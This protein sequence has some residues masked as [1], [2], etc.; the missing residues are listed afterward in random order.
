MYLPVRPTPNLPTLH[1]R[2]IKLAVIVKI[3]ILKN[4][5]LVNNV[6][7]VTGNPRGKIMNRPNGKCPFRDYL[8][9]QAYFQSRMNK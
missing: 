1:T 6:Y 4:K 8:K 3:L 7:I 9:L 5:F 2:S